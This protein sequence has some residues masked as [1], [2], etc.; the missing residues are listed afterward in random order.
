[1]PVFQRVPLNTKLRDH[2]P[3][4]TKALLPFATGP[5]QASPVEGAGGTLEDPFWSL[6]GALP[7]GSLLLPQTRATFPAHH[8][9]WQNYGDF[10]GKALSIH[11]LPPHQGGWLPRESRAHSHRANSATHGPWWLDPSTGE[12]EPR[13]LIPSFRGCAGSALSSGCSQTCI[14]LSSQ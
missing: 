13:S 7:V 14:P 4:V 12:W 8:S 11:G 2:G 5:C 10:H 9:H 1:M 6:R 3:A